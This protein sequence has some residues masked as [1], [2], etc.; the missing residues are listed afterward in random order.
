MFNDDIQGTAAVASACV[1]AGLQQAGSTLA[2]TPVLIVGAGSAGCGIAAML[3][4][5]AGSPQ[6]VQLFDQDGLVCLDRANLTPSQQPFARPSQEA[7]T[8]LPELIARLRPGVLIGVSGQGGLFTEQVLGAMGEVC[9]RPVILPLSNPT[10]SA[11]ATPEQVW[12][13][14]EGRALLATG[15]PFAPVMVAE[16]ARGGGAGG[17]GLSPG[18]RPLAASH[19]SGGGGGPRRRQSRGPGRPRGGVGGFCR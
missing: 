11:E 6:Q 19:R 16:E 17:R 7:C 2:D 12:R 10:R 15:S 5:L 4:R 14:T 3:A 13:A 18:D 9:E 1:L 8:S